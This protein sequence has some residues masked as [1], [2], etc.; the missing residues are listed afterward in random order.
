MWVDH[1]GR[2]RRGVVG[3]V[4]GGVGGEDGMKRG[5]LGSFPFLRP[6]SECFTQIMWN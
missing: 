1:V 5:V 6:D 2:A 4:W 3:K